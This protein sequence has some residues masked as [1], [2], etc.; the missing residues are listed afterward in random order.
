MNDLPAGPLQ[1]HGF[2]QH[3][4]DPG[5]LNPPHPAGGKAIHD[6]IPWKFVVCK[7]SF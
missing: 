5:L 2:F 4:A 6:F 7:I 1:G 3:A